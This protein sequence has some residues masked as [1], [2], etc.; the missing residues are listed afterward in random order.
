MAQLR[1]IHSAFDT[2]RTA[3]AWRSSV[4]FKGSGFSTEQLTARGTGIVGRMTR[5]VDVF[6]D[7]TASWR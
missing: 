7:A 3:A 2:L 5:P 1:P 4:Y 6:P